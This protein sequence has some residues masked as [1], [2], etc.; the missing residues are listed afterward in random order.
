[1]S[2][3]FGSGTT[4]VSHFWTEFVARLGVKNLLDLM[5]YAE[6]ESSY[7]VFAFDTGALAIT[8][9]I[10]R[11]EVPDAVRSVYPQSQNDADLADFEANYKPNANQALV[12]RALDGRQNSL[13]NLFPSGVVLYIPGAGD[14][15][16]GVGEG[17][18][19][20]SQSSDVVPTDHEVDFGFLDVV[21][22][23]GGQFAYTGAVVGD[24]AD[25]V[26]YAPPTNTTSTP[27][28]GNADVVGGALIVPAVGGSAT[29]DLTKAIP[30][31]NPTGTGRWDWTAAPDLVGPG[32]IAPN[33]AGKG[34]YD[35]YAVEVPLTH[36]VASVPMVGDNQVS[37]TVPA[38]V[39]ARLL[40]Q[41]RH[42]VRIRNSGGSHALSV[43]WSLVMARAR[44]TT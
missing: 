3:T 16:A 32:A 27:G 39:P 1:M 9:T 12:P 33:P 17:A 22:L 25:Y 18:L 21:Y 37:L 30:V 29:V 20:Q 31:P 8:C 10:W 5:Q 41:W 28:A 43:V 13:P 14:D 19:F 15:A 26:V 4:V 7:T 6:D 11:G 38:I 44:T 40:P 36:F 42:R 23:A 35:L 24:S 2:V 34:W